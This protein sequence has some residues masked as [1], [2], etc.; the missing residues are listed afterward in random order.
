ME[1]G[2]ITISKTVQAAASFYL[3]QMDN[4]KLFK[5]YDLGRA[6]QIF[7]RFVILINFILDFYVCT[8]VLLIALDLG[9]IENKISFLTE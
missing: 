5:E 6:A 1:I 4:L 9:G 7:F 2:N 3:P 8:L